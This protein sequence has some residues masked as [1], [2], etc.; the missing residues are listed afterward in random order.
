ME[1]VFENRDNGYKSALFS[2]TNSA[3]GTDRVIAYAGTDEWQDYIGADA[4]IVMGKVS[5]QWKEALEFYQDNKEDGLT[6][7]TG[8]SMGGG[9]AQMVGSMAD[10]SIQVVTFN[11]PGVDGHTTEILE[12]RS[13]PT[14]Y[15]GDIQR[16]VHVEFGKQ[17]PNRN[18]MNYSDYDDAT[19]NFGTHIGELKRVNLRGTD[20]LFTY[21]SSDWWQDAGLYDENG[22]IMPQARHKGNYLERWIKSQTGQNDNRAEFAIF[23]MG[24]RFDFITNKLVIYKGYLF[25]EYEDIMQELEDVKFDIGAI[26]GGILGGIAVVGVAVAVVATGVGIATGL[27]VGILAAIPV[28]VVVVGA[29]IAADAWKERVLTGATR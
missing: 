15:H 23:N 24:N 6:G 11:A 8:H 27:I 10:E 28:A 26:V 9:L 29:V 3:G 22:N 12:R 5:H 14:N 1:K 13:F 4:D 25:T 7:I 17:G 21:H 19:G 20:F 16:D 18:I 2:R